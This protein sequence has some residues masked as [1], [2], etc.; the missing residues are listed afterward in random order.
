MKLVNGKSFISTLSDTNGTTITEFSSAKVHCLSNF[1]NICFNHSYHRLDDT[2]T[3]EY[4]VE[5]A[6]FTWSPCQ[7]G[8]MEATESVHR[9]FMSSFQIMVFK[10]S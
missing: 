7:E 1:K 3:P 8:E 4:H 9:F 5:Y 6:C 2:S 10:L